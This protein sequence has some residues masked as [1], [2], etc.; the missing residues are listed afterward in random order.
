MNKKPQAEAA[1]GA[2][3]ATQK[4]P[5][6]KI[7]KTTFDF[8]TLTQKVNQRETLSRH[9]TTLNERTKTIDL[10]DLTDG[11]KSTDQIH[12]IQFEFGDRY[13]NYKIHNP[14]LLKETCNFIA[15]RLNE[16]IQSL[17]EEIQVITSL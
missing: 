17:E 15:S 13:N 16:K 6:M 4:N 3:P 5:E 11:E 14:V 10:T 9:L 7:S 2:S 12:A 8:A 1:P